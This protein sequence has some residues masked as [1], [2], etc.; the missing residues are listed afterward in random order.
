MALVDSKQY[1]SGYGLEELWKLSGNEFIRELKQITQ[2]F[3]DNNEIKRPSF[4]H[5]AAHAETLTAIFEVLNV[6]WHIRSTPS[7]AVFFEFIDLIEEKY[8]EEIITPIIQVLY[9]DGNTNSFEYLMMRNGKDSMTLVE[10]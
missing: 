9:H 8:G 2:D 4:Q 10:L 3:L 6:H 7:S 5:Y 1:A